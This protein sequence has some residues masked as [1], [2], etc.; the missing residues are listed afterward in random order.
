[1][2]A[3]SLPRD[4]FT[5]NQWKFPMGFDAPDEN[6]GKAQ[7]GTRQASGVPHDQIRRMV[8]RRCGFDSIGLRKPLKQT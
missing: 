7:T 5:A 6:R 8:D 1:M 4:S 3:A 2:D